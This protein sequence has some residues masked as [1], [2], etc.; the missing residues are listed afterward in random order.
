MSHTSKIGRMVRNPGAPAG[1]TRSARRGGKQPARR[2]L[3]RLER[4]EER[5]TP[6]IPRTFQLD[7]NVTTAGPRTSGSTTTPTGTHADGDI[8]LVSDFTTGGSVST[9]KVFRWT[10]DD[11]TGKLVAL[12]NGN[13]ITGSTFAIVNSGPIS[14]P[15][16]YT[17]K[18]GQTQPAAGEFLEEGVDLTALGLQGCFSTFLAETRSSQSPTATL[19]DFVTGS[20]PLCGLTATPFTGLSKVG[21]SVTYPLTV[22]N[23]G[24]IPLSIQNVTDTLLGNIVVN[25]V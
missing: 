7:G 17:N 22:K 14:V 2:C 19:S 6:T 21:D 15:W 9:I 5:G 10:G 25:G 1:R 8:L 23:T 13:P 20:F 3:L 16:S 24:A 12:N 11:S 18:S 4:L